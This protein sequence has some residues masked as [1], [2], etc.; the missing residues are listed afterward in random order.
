MLMF[1]DGDFKLNDI[2]WSV[3]EV[4]NVWHFHR[5]QVVYCRAP[6]IIKNIRTVAWLSKEENIASTQYSSC[7][8]HALINPR[9]EQWLHNHALV[10]PRP[11]QWLYNHALVN[12][13]PVQ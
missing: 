3:S 11:V 7:K 13:R 5:R 2:G 10:N 6:K 9:P 4:W 12:P 1:M 8:N